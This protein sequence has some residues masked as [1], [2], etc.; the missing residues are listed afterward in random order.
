VLYDKPVSELMRQAA[1][2]LAPPYSPSD[3]V[4]W[5]Q[6]HYPKVNPKTVRMHIKGLTSNDPSR[7][8]YHVARFT[9]LFF[10]T[11]NG[12]EPFDPDKHLGLEEEEE[13]EEEVDEHEGPTDQETEFV[14]ES[15]LEEFLESNWKAIGWHRPLHLWEGPNGRIGHQLVT[16]V[17]RIDFL[18]IDKSTNALVVVELKRGRPSDKVVGQ[19]ARYMG[20]VRV[21]LASKGQS[22]EGLI[23]ARQSDDSLGY[24]VSAVPGLHLMTYELDFRLQPQDPPAPKQPIQ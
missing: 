20:W 5:F 6:S 1:E 21:N 12:L 10:R 9:P 17:G 24:A 16:P 19:T 7:H 18:C 15:Q 14:L 23:V 8:H 13:N 11:P 22:V 4:A 3:F 2:D